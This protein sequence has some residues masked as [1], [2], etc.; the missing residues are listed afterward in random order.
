MDEMKIEI[1]GKSFHGWESF[2]LARTIDSCADGFSMTSIFDPENLD[3][4][5]AFKP[6]GY[7]DCIVKIDEEIILTGTVEVTSPS[8]NDGNNEI[9]VQ[10]RSKTGILVDCSIYDVGFQFDGLKLSAIAQKLCQK[11]GIT[12]IVN[13]DSGIISEARANPGDT[14]FEFLNKLAKDNGLILSND[15]L[16]N[17]VISKYEKNVSVASIIEGDSPVK[18]VACNYNGTQRFSIYNLLQQQDGT[19]DI[20]GIAID[21]IKYRPKIITGAT[22]DAK[23]ITKAA[24]WQRALAYAES[25]QVSVTVSGWRNDFDRLWTPGDTIILLSPGTFILKETEFIIAESVLKLDNGTGRTTDLRLVLP[26]TFTGQTPEGY[27]WE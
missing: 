5:N 24:E 27:P 17:L 12:V 11:H 7:Q 16:G 25:I 6:F 4:L 8:I 19:P 23:E 15:Y 18:S 3:I 10:G 1:G 2:S 9:N 13:N 20:S 21:N 22:G 26:S 14:I